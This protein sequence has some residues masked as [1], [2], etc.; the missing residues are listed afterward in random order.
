MI[1]WQPKQLE[2]AR[3]LSDK[4]KKR[5]LL[6]GGRRSGKTFTIAHF[7]RLRSLNYPGCKQLIARKTLKNAAQSVWLETMLP[8]L[9]QDQASGL[10][11]IYRQP[12][13]AEYKNGSLI[14]LGGLAPNEIDDALGKEYSTI[15]PNEGS[16][17]S[18][19]V[20]PALISS[21]NE[22]AKHKETGEEV[23][24]KLIVDMNPTTVKHWSHDMWMLG[25]DPLTKE[26]LKMRE[27]YGTMQINPIDN[28]PNLAAGYYE[29]LEAMSPRD[30]QRFLLGEYGQL[31]GLVYD[32]FDTE[33][34]VYDT[35]KIDP[36]WRLYRTIDFG[37]TN[38]FACYW[39][40][41][42]EAN[43]TLYID[44]EWYHS[45]ITV[46]AHAVKIREITGDRRI[47][48]TVADHDAGDRKILEEAGIPTQKADKD[49]A[50]G[51]NHFYDGLNRGKIKV[52]R[53]CINL[54]NEFYSY[55]WKEAS[56]KDEPIK[57]NDHG[58]DAVRYLYK[59]FMR[60][61][62]TESQPM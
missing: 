59:R 50:S 7:F 24:P 43:E 62:K 21:L 13:L 1:K 46:N 58:L 2:A 51:I 55:Q 31:A 4:T 6:R 52:N 17:I 10:C 23:V 41:Y 53:R 34:H 42:D 60:R 27:I 3:L 32:N 35:V 15:W 39:C 26:P 37:F 14:L 33:Q 30:R 8:I 49:V 12:N 61:R 25:V 45:Q 5:I 57:E 22:R 44:D 29:S 9:K 19:N 38:P 28:L 20:I 47:E 48:T 16:E 54:I 36:K 18:Y 11:R 40:Y 56:K